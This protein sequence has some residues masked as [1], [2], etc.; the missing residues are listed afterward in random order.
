MGL[1]IRKSFTRSICQILGVFQWK[2]CCKSRKS[3]G[4]GVHWFPDHG[5]QTLYCVIFH[6]WLFVSAYHSLPAG[7][8]QPWSLSA[9]NL[10]NALHNNSSETE[11]LANSPENHL[12]ANFLL[13]F[14]LKPLLPQSVVY[15][16]DLCHIHHIH[17]GQTK[18][19]IIKEYKKK[20]SK[21]NSLYVWYSHKPRF[22]GYS[23]PLLWLSKYKLTRWLALT[24]LSRILGPNQFS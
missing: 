3:E 5:R 20:V 24:S 19:E 8:C 22:M 6:I 21:Y 1:C 15:K 11:F 10:Q 7:I 9:R 13:Q 17:E 12:G 4:R 18:S 23:A 2:F 16:V 14:P